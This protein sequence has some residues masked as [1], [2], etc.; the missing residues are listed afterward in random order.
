M[1]VSNA[2]VAP[3]SF[4]NEIRGESRLSRTLHNTHLVVAEHYHASLI[5][6]RAYL[7]E[8]GVMDEVAIPSMS[9]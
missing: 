4:C 1:N 5:Y 3:F 8:D 9:I 6:D 7:T 2:I